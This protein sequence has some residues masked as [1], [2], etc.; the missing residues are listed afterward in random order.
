[1]FCYVH[2]IE[3]N[4]YVMFLPVLGDW[5]CGTGI[6]VQDLTLPPYTGQ[7]SNSMKYMGGDP[8]VLNDLFFLG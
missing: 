2:G 7:Y 5:R 8:P 6:Y 3:D 4:L 1:M